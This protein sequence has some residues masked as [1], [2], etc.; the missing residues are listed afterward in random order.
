VEVY[1]F[2]GLAGIKVSAFPAVRVILF[3]GVGMEFTVHMSM[4]CCLYLVITIFSIGSFKI[5]RL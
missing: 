3:V 5:R 2:M 1:G 4:V